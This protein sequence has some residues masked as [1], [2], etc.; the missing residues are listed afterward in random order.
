MRMF[1]ALVSLNMLLG[2]VYDALPHVHREG[3]NSLVE[4]D[5]IGVCHMHT[6]W[7]Q[8]G[9]LRPIRVD[10]TKCLQVAIKT[11]SFICVQKDT[12]TYEISCSHK[13]H[14]ELVRQNRFFGL[15]PTPVRWEFFSL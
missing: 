7:I 2:R 14:I 1:H 5:L 12:Q 13:K 3:R 6:Y 4:Q 11:H 8:I 9:T 15:V 10:H